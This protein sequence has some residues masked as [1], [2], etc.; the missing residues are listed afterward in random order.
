MQ[1]QFK[2]NVPLCRHGMR[3]D[4]PVQQCSFRNSK[5]N[6]L[7]SSA[8]KGSTPTTSALDKLIAMDRRMHDK[9]S[10]EACRFQHASATPSHPVVS[11]SAASLLSGTGTK[12]ETG[13]VDP[14]DGIGLV[15]AAD[16]VAMYRGWL[17]SQM[18]AQKARIKAMSEQFSIPVPNLESNPFD[19]SPLSLMTPSVGNAVATTTN[20]TM[21]PQANNKKYLFDDRKVP[22]APPA[23][24]IPPALSVPGLWQ[25]ETQGS[26]RTVRAIASG[27]LSAREP[28]P[29]R[30]SP[31]DQGPNPGTPT[32]V[33][34]KHPQ[35][36]S[37]A[38]KKDDMAY[39]TTPCKHYTLNQ[40]WCPW[41]DE[42]GFIHD[43]ELGWVPPLERT[44]GSSTPNSST[45]GGSKSGLYDTAID[46]VI[47]PR[48][49]VSSKSAHC[50]GYIQGICPHSDTCRYLHPTDIVPYI[51][52]TP[53][54][55]WPR[56]G[57]PARD[58]PLKH[59]QVDD[60]VT[61]TH[62]TQP[63]FST[64]T[65]APQARSR[66]AP[67]AETYSD[68]SLA[69]QYHSQPPFMTPALFTPAE[70]L[71]IPHDEAYAS[72][73][74]H[75]RPTMPPAEMFTPAP[76]RP[77]VRL[78]RPS[79]DMPQDQA[80]EMQYGFGMGAHQGRARSVS[81]AVQRLGAEF[82]GPVLQTQAKAFARGH[83][84]GKSLNL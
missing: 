60:K 31:L 77:L 66:I 49:S 33:V 29:P 24:R 16:E 59:L 30:P 68:A 72:A 38:P 36:T 55:T 69:P 14:V 45:L 74:L 23:P 19:S 81:I 12:V 13:S 3:D 7:Y 41:G 51:K 73:K 32:V 21:M 35:V 79:E 50:W 15:Q 65:I 48:R 80:T 37:I 76:V 22:S 54:L 84:R 26:P 28:M 8:F 82:S 27:P 67:R 20:K 61:S 58:C 70:G 43:P 46:V 40:G 34:S 44:S 2:P 56:C 11:D 1:T 6:V 64:T 63:S 17:K 10:G 42:C 39:K 71:V 57:F 78:R 75:H 4:C 47:D 25:P 53:C 9:F 5:P 62:R 52:Y 83:G 18:D